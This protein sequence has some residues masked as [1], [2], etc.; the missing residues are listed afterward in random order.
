VVPTSLGDTDGSSSQSFEQ[1]KAAVWR[2]FSKLRS[3]VPQFERIYKLELL[4]WAT[5]AKPNL[6]GLGPAAKQLLGTVIAMCVGRPPLLKVFCGVD[7]NERLTH[8]L[9]A[10]TSMKQCYTN[11]TSTSAF[12]QLIGK[13]GSSDINEELVY[14]LKD[15]IGVLERSIARQREQQE[16][17][18]PPQ[19]PI[20][21]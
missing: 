16:Q 5:Q 17:Q 6:V 12:S 3:L 15:Q 19:P 2:Q 4:P 11:L 21:E 8:L 10:I 9:K 20:S 18:K 13:N 7:V 1:T 14:N